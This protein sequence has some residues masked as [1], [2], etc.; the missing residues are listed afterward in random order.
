MYMSTTSKNRRY[1]RRKNKVNAIIKASASFPRLIVNKSNAHI[2]AQL[3]D[4]DWTVIAIASDSTFSWTKSEKAHQVWELLASRAL[5]KSVS[6]V[7]FDRNWYLY[8]WRVKQL[9]EWARKWGLTL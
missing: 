2:S 4:L 1:L 3:I 7:V 6:T 5:E 8:H 9:A